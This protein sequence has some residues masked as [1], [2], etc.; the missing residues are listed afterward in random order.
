MRTFS[1]DRESS[2]ILWLIACH[3][4]LFSEGAVRRTSETTC[5]LI[6]ATSECEL[7]ICERVTRASVSPM[8]RSMVLIS[9]DSVFEDFPKK[10]TLHSRIEPLS[11]SF[12]M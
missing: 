5:V 8:Q 4:S 7:F 1:R 10:E 12:L 11:R 3:W 9:S 6:F 2:L